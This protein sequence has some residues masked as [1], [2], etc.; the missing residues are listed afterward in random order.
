MRIQLQWSDRSRDHIARHGL[1]E[2][3]VDAIV[4][5][6]YYMRKHGGRLKLIG[7]TA[8]RF[9]LVVLEP[10]RTTRNSFVV[11]TARRAT[12]AEKRLFL[13]KVSQ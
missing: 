1:S 13:K 2:I 5:G 8:D 6:R 12:P 4:G 10:I 3:D 9:L 7:R 11:V